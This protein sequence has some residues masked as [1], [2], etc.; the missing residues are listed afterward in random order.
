MSV[1]GGGAYPGTALPRAAGLRKDGGPQE[2]SS[3]QR[4]L[5]PSTEDDFPRRV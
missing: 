1:V 2:A 4:G 3:S 5:H